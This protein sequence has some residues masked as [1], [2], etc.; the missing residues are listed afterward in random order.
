MQDTQGC[1]LLYRR[2]PEFYHLIRARGFSPGPDRW[3]AVHDL[4]FQL[5]A[6]GNEPKSAKELLHLLAPLFCSSPEDQ[7]IFSEL[8]LAWSAGDVQVLEHV[9]ILKTNTNLTSVSKKSRTKQFLAKLLTITILLFLGC[10]IYFSVTEEKPFYWV[11]GSDDVDNFIVE[12]EPENQGLNDKGLLDEADELR[13]A[14][15]EQEVDDFSFDPDEQVSVSDFNIDDDQIQL[16]LDIYPIPPRLPMPARALPESHA[17]F[18]QAGLWFG[19]IVFPLLILYLSKILSNSHRKKVLKREKRGAKNNLVYLQLKAGKSMP[20][21]LG[22]FSRKLRR[23]VRVSTRLLDVAKTINATINR[24]GLFTPVALYRNQAPEYLVLLDRSHYANQLAALGDTLIQRLYYEHINVHHYYYRGDPRWCY[25]KHGDEYIAI[26]IETLISQ[27][28]NARLII[29]GEGQGLFSDFN[30]KIV[31]WINVFNHWGCKIWLTNRPQPWS[32]R[33]SQLAENGFAV[34]PIDSGGLASIADWLHNVQDDHANGKAAPWFGGF[35]DHTYPSSFLHPEEWLKKTPPRNKHQEARFKTMMEQLAEYLGIDGMNLLKACAAY[36]ELNGNLTIALDQKLYPFEQPVER[37]QRLIRMSNLPWCNKG[38]MPDYI[39]KKL[40]DGMNAKAF[41]ALSDIYN[42]LF[43]MGFSDTSGLALAALNDTPRMRDYPTQAKAD[44]PSR[45][46]LLVKVLR[47]R[48]S[49]LDFILPESIAKKFR[50][51]SS[52]A[53]S[54]LVGWGLALSVCI[55]FLYLWVPI[56]TRL[57]DWKMADFIENNTNT[58][59]LIMSDGKTHEQAM[60]LQSHLKEYG[61]KSLLLGEE[62][63]NSDAFKQV[64]QYSSKD[65]SYPLYIYTQKESSGSTVKIIRDALQHIR[66]ETRSYPSFP[67]IKDSFTLPSLPED[68]QNERFVIVILKG[69]IDSF[70]S[71]QEELSP[72]V[73]FEPV[74]PGWYAFYGDTTEDLDKELAENCSPSYTS[75]SVINDTSYSGLCSSLGLECKFVCDANGER[76]ACATKHVGSPGNKLAKEG[77][78][79]VKGLA[80]CASKNSEGRSQRPL[81]KEGIKRLFM[82]GDVYE[83]GTI[84]GKKPFNSIISTGGY[85][86]SRYYPNGFN[87]SASVRAGYQAA[88]WKVRDDGALCI[89]PIGPVNRDVCYRIVPQE[90]NTYLASDINTGAVASVFSV[91]RDITDIRQKGYRFAKAYV[92]GGRIDSLS[93]IK[94]NGEV[95]GRSVV[96]GEKVIV[97][98]AFELNNMKSCPT[99]IVQLRVG[100]VGEKDVDCLYLGTP[101]VEGTAVT[102]GKGRVVLRAPNKPGRYVLSYDKTM[103]YSCK[104]TRDKS[105]E[106][107]AHILG[108]IDVLGA[109]NSGGAVNNRKLEAMGFKK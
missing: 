44:V 96:P 64:L 58:S 60:A 13:E 6:D 99:C 55:T 2:L 27:H 104:K 80:W 67:S 14:Q 25:K 10:S 26:N 32:Y 45:D 87:Q 107:S 98:G 28:P 73:P 17:R 41:S 61:F 82:D 51:H 86:F 88:R 4:L 75:T 21:A 8:F 24:A 83:I 100:F 46:Q 81:S 65:V 43:L 74:Q 84:K 11:S 78:S 66:Y 15:P 29:I 22:S 89:L 63:E 31:S 54:K 62:E 5:Q 71:F 97:E 9:S 92:E 19:L 108:F 85:Y 52:F 40:L 79:S 69:S 102:K 34:A 49:R 105:P 93:S 23:S 37:E 18:I 39:R 101:R 59:V 72:E 16:E 57:M 48:R 33:E 3:L 56:Q 106:D 95:F 77:E 91:S 76:K 12:E 38:L 1:R 7:Q 103:A 68:I 35:H 94:I 47:G 53:W 70:F 20:Y 50:G 30:E 42:E 90:N 36:P 109:R